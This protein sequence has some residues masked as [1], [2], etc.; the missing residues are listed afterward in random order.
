MQ[1]VTL[2]N[3]QAYLFSGKCGSLIVCWCIVAVLIHGSMGKIKL[4]G[5][6]NKLV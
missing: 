4:K 6:D 2:H 5:G 3:I 1:W